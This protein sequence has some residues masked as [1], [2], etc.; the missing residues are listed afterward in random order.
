MAWITELSGGAR[1]VVFIYCAQLHT[2][3]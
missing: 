2:K 3:V 1:V